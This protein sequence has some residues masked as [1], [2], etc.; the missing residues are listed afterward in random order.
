MQKTKKKL[1]PTKFILLGYIVIILLGGLLLTLPISSRQAVWTP[2]VD[3]LFTATSATCV[4][5]L[6][7]YD[8][9][10]YWSSFGQAVILL[11]IQIGGVGFMTFAISL[12]TMTKKKIGLSQ[13]S[14][15]QESVAAPQLGGIVKMT[16][17]IL[18]GSLLV[19]GMGALLLTFYFCPR[20]GLGKGLY[21]SVFHSISAFCNAGFDLMGSRQPFSSLTLAADN[22]YLNLIIMLLIIIGGLGFFV[23]FDLLHNRLR[24]KKLRLHSK[25][26]LSVSGILILVGTCLLFLLEINGEAF[27][28]KSLGQK[29]LYSLF[30]SVTVRTAGFN[31]ADLA[32][33]SQ[34]SQLV[35]IVL[36][37]VGG[38]PGSTAGGMKTTTFAIILLSVMTTFQRR[39]AIEC[40]GRR[41][42][43]ETLRAASCVLSLYLLLTLVSTVLICAIEG[44]DIMA[45][46]FEASSAVATVGLTLGITPSLGIL[47]EIILL[48]LMIFGRVGSITMLLAFAG[49]PANIVSRLPAESVRVG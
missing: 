26:V 43:D 32:R 25:I 13:R 40:Y 35:M 21:F 23:W 30:Q 10:T 17:F 5:G 3:A 33:M 39:K 16:R 22:V 49:A 4:T 12:I 7:R 8:T 20:L 38:S 29:L 48:F 46:A 14:I 2:I 37:L 24:F 28:G 44:I 27:A 31:T 11:L 36:M 41:I 42:E 1:S 15:M 9:Y 6:I 45:V 34:P 47:S 19:E 18:L